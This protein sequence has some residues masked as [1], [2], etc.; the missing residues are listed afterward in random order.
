MTLIQHKTY[1]T[2]MTCTVGQVA[3]NEKCG[4]KQPTLSQITEKQTNFL[5]KISC[6]VFI[7]FTKI[8]KRFQKGLSSL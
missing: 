8:K 6:H 2:I 5:L 7:N 3:M 1:V 4:V